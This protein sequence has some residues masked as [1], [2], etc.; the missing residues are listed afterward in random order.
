MN[1]GFSKALGIA[2]YDADP[3][4]VA[5]RQFDIG[6]TRT[7]VTVLADRATTNADGT[8]RRELDVQYAVNYMDGSKDEVATQTLISGSSS[9]ATMADKA[10]CAVAE[11]KA[12]WRFFGN[13]K[14]VNTSVNANNLRTSRVALA[15]G[16]PLA[17]QVVYSK[18]IHLNVI[19]PAGVATYAIVTGPGLSLTTTGQAGSLKYISPRL[20]RSATEFAGKRGNFVDWKDTDAFRSCSNAAGT[21]SASAELA[22]CT[23]DGSTG[24]NSWGSFNQTNMATMDSFFSSLNINAGAVYTFAI[25]GD[26]GWKT[27][28]GQAGKTPIA[29]YTSTL[30]A[31]PFSGATLAG[32]GPATDLF[33]KLLT[34]GG[35][36]EAQFAAAILAKSALSVAATWSAPAAMPDSRALALGSHN[37]YEQG[38]AGA[39]PAFN[40]ASRQSYANYAGPTATAGTFAKPASVS[41]LVTPTYGELSLNYGNR[42]GN[43]VFSVYSF[44]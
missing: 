2:G 39:G 10:V 44:Q 3:L 36:T 14:V 38:R 43:G 42:N 8:T 15:T 24:G 30:E 26:D 37:Y 34:T 33:P 4:R 16:L 7:N 41:A 29:T 27:V 19:D 21:G 9:G 35:V 31:V 5:S 12:D 22:N 6:S 32:T 20:L 11:N 23:V 18:Y 17:P 13:R 40:P 28:N 25:Y 1:N